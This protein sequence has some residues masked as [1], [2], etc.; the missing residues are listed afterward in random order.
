ML[1]LAI[2][3]ATVVTPSGVAR[4]DVGLVA[5]KIASIALPG[6]LESAQRTD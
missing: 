4:A 1:D 2:V 5:D 3:G 6:A